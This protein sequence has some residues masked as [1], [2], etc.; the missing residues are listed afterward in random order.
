MDGLFWLPKSNQA[1]G[2]ETPLVRTLSVALD[3]QPHINL[4]LCLRI[5]E[6]P[7]IVS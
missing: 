2:A 7:Y 6:F 1:L 5:R 3:T 4:A